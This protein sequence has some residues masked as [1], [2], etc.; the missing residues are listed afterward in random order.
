ME[1]IEV[2]YRNG[3]F[4]PLKKV[5][6]KEGTKGIVVLTRGKELVEFA[7]KHRKKVQEDVLAVFL[8]ERR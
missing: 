6:L 7:R 4:V 3:V 8:E 5:H 1:R 2:V